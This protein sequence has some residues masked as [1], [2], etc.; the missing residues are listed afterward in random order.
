MKL[1]LDK[2][3]DQPRIKAVK[4]VTLS[5]QD[6]DSN[7]PSGPTLCLQ[8]RSDCTA[9]T[10]STSLV[11]KVF[12]V[13]TTCSHSHAFSLQLQRLLVP[14]RRGRPSIS[15]YL[16]SPA[17]THPSLPHSPGCADRHKTGI[18]HS[19][20]FKISGLNCTSAGDDHN[21]A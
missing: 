10:L 13:V 17:K 9:R 15:G 18:D 4:S 3:G 5:G 14:I 7:W 2:K 1:Q 6:A 8:S 21:R 16:C 19:G 12:K 20:F 11:P